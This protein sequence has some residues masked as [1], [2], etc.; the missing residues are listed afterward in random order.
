[1]L[2]PEVA[3]VLRAFY[4][5]VSRHPNVQEAMWGAEEYLAAHMPDK[6]PLPS[7]TPY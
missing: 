6:L 3:E 2:E 5:Q 4:L 1:M 7:Y